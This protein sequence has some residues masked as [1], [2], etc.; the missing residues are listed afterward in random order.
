MSN[1]LEPL[2]KLH[3]DQLSATIE[4][5]LANYLDKWGDHNVIQLAAISKCTPPNLL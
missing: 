1:L 4:C 5:V 2:A 3:I